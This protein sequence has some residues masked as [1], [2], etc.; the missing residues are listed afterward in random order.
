MINNSLIELKKLLTSMEEDFG[1]NQLSEV[2]PKVF[3]HAG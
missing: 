2:E 3:F 1:L